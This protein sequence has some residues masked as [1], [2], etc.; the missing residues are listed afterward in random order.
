MDVK[1]NEE[2]AIKKELFWKIFSQLELKFDKSVPI[3][4]IITETQKDFSEDEIHEIIEKL[5]RVGDIYSPKH[6][7]VSRL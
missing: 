4:D 6:G 1:D 2:T 7:F 5:K 3:E